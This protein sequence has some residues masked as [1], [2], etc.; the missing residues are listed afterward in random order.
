[1]LDLWL[2]RLNAIVF[3]MLALLV[4]GYRLGRCKK[5]PDAG[6]QPSEIST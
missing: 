1:M 4:L 2:L 5:H 6:F 3:Q